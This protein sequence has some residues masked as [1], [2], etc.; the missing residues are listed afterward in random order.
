MRRSTAI[1]SICTAGLLLLSCRTLSGTARPL[2]QA[3]VR[4]AAGAQLGVLSFTPTADGVRIK[5]DLKGLSAGTH[6]IHIHAVGLCD[7]PAFTTA[8]A[9]FNPLGAK[10]GLDNPAGPHAGDMQNIAVDSEGEAEVGITTGR[11]TL[12]AM[13]PTGLFDSDGSAIVI[14]AAADDQVTDP[15][16]NSGARIACGVIQKI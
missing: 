9:H 16:G 7:G 6:G 3:T 11:V 8:G 1:L 2:A 14:H 4:S 10:H 5:G 15:S 12:D 13:M